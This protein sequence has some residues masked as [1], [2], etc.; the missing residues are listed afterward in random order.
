MKREPRRVRAEPN[1]SGRMIVFPIWVIKKRDERTKS[2]VSKCKKKIYQE[3]REREK[4]TSG[5]CD[6]CSGKI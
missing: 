2:V 1:V 5:K 6:I 4:H 3:E